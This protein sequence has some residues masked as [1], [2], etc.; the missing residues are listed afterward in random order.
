MND[1]KNE[2]EEKEKREKS[3]LSSDSKAEI[4]PN[5]RDE[6][7]EINQNTL[8]E[9]VDAMIRPA[10]AKIHNRGLRWKDQTLEKNEKSIKTAKGNIE[11]NDEIKSKMIKKSIRINKSETSMSTASAFENN[12]SYYEYSKKP[13]LLKTIN[14]DVT[15]SETSTS[16][17][18][19]DSTII[20]SQRHN[21]EKNQFKVEHKKNKI[22]KKDEKKELK[23]E[24]KANIS[25]TRKTGLYT[26]KYAFEESLI[27]TIA[28]ILIVMKKCRIL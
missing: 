5:I 27:L 22:D 6:D 10:R 18:Q 8:F 14:D 12:Q 19:H 25:H 7:S 13:S 26:V 24:K 1:I 28:L 3:L 4:L 15:T 16:E 23:I 2:T 21:I 11:N 17:T 20:I 9:E